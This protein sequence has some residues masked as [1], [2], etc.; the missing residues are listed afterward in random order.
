MAEI[1]LPQ[2]APNRRRTSSAA[3]RVRESI[4]KLRTLPL[5]EVDRD[6]YEL[7]LKKEADAAAFVSANLASVSP[8]D[9]AAITA[10]IQE[11]DCEIQNENNKKNFERQFLGLAIVGLMFAY[12]YY[13]TNHGPWFRAYINTLLTQLENIVKNYIK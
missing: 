11:V 10:A 12:F 6:L 4:D 8:D 13:D 7:S 9:D 2:N 3:D 5:D 1:T